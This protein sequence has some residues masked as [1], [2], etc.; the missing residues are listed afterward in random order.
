[1]VALAVSTKSAKSCQHTIMT[2]VEFIVSKYLVS[3]YL[4]SNPNFSELVFLTNPPHLTL[5]QQEYK[6]SS[7]CRTWDGTRFRFGINNWLKML[8]VRPDLA[9]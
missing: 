6:F 2:R 7:E 5:S 9:D 3:E 1:M 4:S 8:F